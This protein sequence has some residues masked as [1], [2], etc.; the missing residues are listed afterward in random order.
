M[1]KTYKLV[2]RVNIGVDVL[3][4]SSDVFDFGDSSCGVLISWDRG[5]S[6]RDLDTKGSRGRDPNSEECTDA[7]PD[8][9]GS[10]DREADIKDSAGCTDGLDLK[11][12]DP[13]VRG[14]VERDL[15]S[16]RSSDP[17]P[18]MR[19]DCCSVIVMIGS[20]NRGTGA[21][22]SGDRDRNDSDPDALRSGDVERSI[23]VKD[24]GDLGLGKMSTGDPGSI[25]TGFAKET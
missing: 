21:R 13:D 18:R 22:R 25:N 20:S 14:S 12:R 17:V 15:A 6:D 9:K 8:A 19:G 4:S 10:K 24:S 1:F 7:D 3:D 16:D 2:S 5:S 11:G 23:G